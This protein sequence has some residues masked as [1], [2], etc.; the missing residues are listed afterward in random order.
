MKKI[1]TSALTAVMALVSCGKDDNPQ[2]QDKI[3]NPLIG[4]W[5][6]QTKTMN[7]IL[8]KLSDCD[9]KEVLVFTDK[10]INRIESEMKEGICTPLG[11]DIATYTISGN[12]FIETS[13]N[14]KEEFTFTVN[15]NMLT[16]NLVEQ[17]D[18]VIITTITTYKKR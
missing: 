9:R 15:A 2:N 14:E 16:M 11:D 18:K 12:K 5:D 7:G 8:K 17:D 13:D 1:V 6:I 10:T 3:V 4:T